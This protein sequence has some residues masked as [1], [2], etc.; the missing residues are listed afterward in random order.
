M[1]ARPPLPWVGFVQYARNRQC[2]PTGERG[3]DPG[4]SGPTSTLCCARGPSGSRDGKHFVKTE[5]KWI[6][7]GR[8]RAFTL[9]ELLV[10][11]AIIAIL[12]G[13]L[14]PAVAKVQGKARAVNCLSQLRQVGL[15]TLMYADDHGDRLPRSSHSATAYGELPWGY[16]LLPYLGWPACTPGD[17][18]WTNVFNSI[19][20]CPADRRRNSDW[21]YGKSVYPELSAQETG[22][23]TWS[24][25]PDLPNATATILFAEKLGGSMADHIMANFWADGGE[26][27][28]DRKRHETRSNYI[29]G[30]GHAA[31]T[32]FE[33]TYDPERDID[34]WNPETAH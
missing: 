12:A 30:D 15:A 23:R 21:S 1:A 24:R 28:V 6:V 34:N 13:L 32:A 17:P 9:V 16:A 22:G 27:E 29:F 4:F 31:G 3:T 20:R 5:T 7:E 10:V 26:P 33:R 11:I 8:L 2:G 25:L 19:Y 14:L 18:L